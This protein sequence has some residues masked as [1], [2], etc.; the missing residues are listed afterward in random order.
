M[1]RVDP[2]V[3]RRYAVA[4]MCT[5]YSGWYFFGVGVSPGVSAGRV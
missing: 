5:R 4:T 3:E 2:L 1:N